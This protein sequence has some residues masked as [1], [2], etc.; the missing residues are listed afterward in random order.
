MGG[1]EES[2]LNMVK[3]IPN[4][5]TGQIMKEK[6]P[7]FVSHQK[8]SA[9]SC[10]LSNTRMRVRTLQPAVSFIKGNNNCVK[11]LISRHGKN[12]FCLDD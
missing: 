5:Y 3:M 10:H 2:L 6:Y 4:G 9:I 8:F 11:Y 7:L 1:R 12:S